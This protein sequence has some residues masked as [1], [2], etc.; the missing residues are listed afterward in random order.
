MVRTDE[1]GGGDKW[2]NSIGGYGHGTDLPTASTSLVTTALQLL[3][4][5]REV[6]VGR[7]RRK[8][9]ENEWRSM[10]KRFYSRGWMQVTGNL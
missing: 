4:C 6:G 1:G 3:I 2:M 10:I 7:V 8:K 9:D 5:P